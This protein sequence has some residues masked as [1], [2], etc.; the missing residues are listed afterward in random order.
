MLVNIDFK[1]VDGADE[2]LYEAIRTA[3]TNKYGWQK[4]FDYN[5]VSGSIMDVLDNDDC[6]SKAHDMFVSAI[7]DVAN[8]EHQ[9]I[10]VET[11]EVMVNCVAKVPN[12]GDKKECITFKNYQDIIIQPQE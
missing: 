11:L 7:Q 9:I 10:N 5:S 6:I 2:K 12:P 3:L 1:L 4:S 8:E